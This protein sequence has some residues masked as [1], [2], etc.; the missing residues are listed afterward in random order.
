MKQTRST[1]L[2]AWVSKDKM[3][4]YLKASILKI[5]SINPA[6]DELKTFIYLINKYYGIGAARDLGITLKLKHKLPSQNFKT[7]KDFLEQLRLTLLQN[8]SAIEPS[9]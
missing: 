2:K 8:S 3:K 4:Y 5:S 6:S 1:S 9:F 7:K